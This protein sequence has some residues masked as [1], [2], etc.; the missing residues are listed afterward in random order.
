MFPYY[1]FHESVE[2]A[3]RVFVGVRPFQIADYA[4]GDP[5]GHAYSTGVGN[6]KMVYFRLAYVQ[7]ILGVPQRRE[8][9][10]HDSG[11][12]C[13]LRPRGVIVYLH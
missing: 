10:S 6:L 7:Q 1:F 11:L 3:R 13:L 8:G 9:R 12:P 2:H 5:E 4:L